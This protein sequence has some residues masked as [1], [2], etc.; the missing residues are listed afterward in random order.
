[1]MRRL[2]ILTFLAVSLVMLVSTPLA[3]SKGYALECR[4][5]SECEVEC[6]NGRICVVF[7]QTGCLE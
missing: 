2:S 1:M 6:C 5:I 3:S 7:T 4:Q